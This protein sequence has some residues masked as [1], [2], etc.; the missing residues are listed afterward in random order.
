[1]SILIPFVG[2]IQGL[3]TI[4]ALIHICALV[5]ILMTL[6]TVIKNKVGGN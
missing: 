5:A 6:D 3:V 1:M 4:G 2:D